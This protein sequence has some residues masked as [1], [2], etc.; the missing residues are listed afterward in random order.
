MT[1]QYHSYLYTLANTM[2]CGVLIEIAD[3]MLG[4]KEAVD[5]AHENGMQ[6][7]V[8]HTD[9][10]TETAA[11]I[12]IHGTETDYEIYGDSAFGSWTRVPPKFVPPLR[13]VDGK[14]ERKLLSLDYLDDL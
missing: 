4:Y 7:L 5:Y 12:P 8:L 11:L 14:R 1:P 13:R 9:D 10:E 2:P 3:Y 6:Y